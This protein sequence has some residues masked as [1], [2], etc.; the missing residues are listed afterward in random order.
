MGAALSRMGFADYAEVHAMFTFQD[1]RLLYAFAGAVALIALIFLVV[2]RLRPVRRKINPG[3][4]LGGALFGMG[5]AITGACPSTM[6]V[7]LGE[8]QLAAILTLVGCAL[9]TLW[10]PKVHARFFKWDMGGCS[11]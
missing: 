8:G 9:G 10:Y 7:Q 5:W 4:F 1:L 11:M 6:L 2:L 3:T